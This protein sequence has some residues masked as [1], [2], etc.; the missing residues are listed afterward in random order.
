[1]ITPFML[2]LMAMLTSFICLLNVIIVIVEFI[3][4]RERA[5]WTI[6]Q[7]AMW[8]FVIVMIWITMP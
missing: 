3:K 5:F 2:M 4:G 8:I 1:M 6:V 7:A